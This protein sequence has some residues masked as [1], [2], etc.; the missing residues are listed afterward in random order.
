MLAVSNNEQ[1]VIANVA[2]VLSVF[3][4]VLILNATTANNNNEKAK[5]G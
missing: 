3:F 5:I 1:I 4:L 2:P